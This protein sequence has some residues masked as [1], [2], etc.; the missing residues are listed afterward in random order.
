[1]CERRRA[2][3]SLELRGRSPLLP[4]G[5]GIEALREI[6]CFYFDHDC[7]ADHCECAILLF[8]SHARAVANPT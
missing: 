7:F 6:G 5:I 2:Q 4:K 1:M 3:Q 8:E